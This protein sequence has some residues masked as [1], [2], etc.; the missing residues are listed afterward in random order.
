MKDIELGAAEIG[1]AVG[2]W[3][4]GK[5]KIAANKVLEGTALPNDPKG[6]FI[7]TLRIRD[8]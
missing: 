4:E 8:H 3:I 1:I 5:T 6:E 2:L 7:V